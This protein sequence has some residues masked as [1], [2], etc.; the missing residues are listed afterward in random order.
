M[1][2]V[3]RAFLDRAAPRLER[4]LAATR[5]TS[6]FASWSDWAS[7]SAMAADSSSLS[8]LGR[9][10]SS[11]TM[12]AVEQS[13]SSST[14]PKTG[15][16]LTRQITGLT[17]P[18]SNPGSSSATAAQAATAPAT[19]PVRRRPFWRSTPE[20]ASMYPV[21]AT[22]STTNTPC[23]PTST[24]SM[25]ANRRPGHRMSWKTR[26]SRAG[27]SARTCAV[28]SSPSAP[29]SD[30]AAAR[31]SRSASALFRSATARADSPAINPPIDLCTTRL[32]PRGPEV[33]GRGKSDA[34]N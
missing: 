25:L 13:I 20:R 24:W 11:V 30:K 18:A 3:S 32:R 33:R 29:R 6:E 1:V 21:H 4:T 16:G 23:G 31:R 34:L 9:E 17:R 10:D 14:Q 15:S 12:F 7:S 2:C 19:A 28:A 27:S 22:L 26:Q 8:T 5:G